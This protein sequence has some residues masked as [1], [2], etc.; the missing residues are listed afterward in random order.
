MLLIEAKDLG[1]SLPLTLLDNAEVLHTKNVLRM[2][3]RNT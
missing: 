1:S 3:V 2:T